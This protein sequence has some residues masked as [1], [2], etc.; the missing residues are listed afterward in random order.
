[1]KNINTTIKQTIK[2]VAVAVLLATPVASSAI[3][4]NTVH[5]AM[6][7]YGDM[8]VDPSQFGPTVHVSYPGLTD[9]SENA[10]SW[11]MYDVE[12]TDTSWRNFKGRTANIYVKDKSLLPAT[13]KAIKFWSP[14][15]KFKLVKS[16]KH[17]S[18]HSK[19]YANVVIYDENYETYAPTAGATTSTRVYENKN[20]KVIKLLGRRYQPYANGHFTAKDLPFLKEHPNSLI[21]DDFAPKA[22]KKDHNKAFTNHLNMVIATKNNSKQA[23]TNKIIANLG[24]TIGL[25]L[26]DND[27]TNATDIM[28]LLYVNDN[29]AAYNKVYHLTQADKDHID[30]IYSHPYTGEV[31]ADHAAEG[32]N[33]Y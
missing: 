25:G 16:A 33:I 8:H 13:K 23:V 15:F 30:W 18:F 4:S 17:A 20:K 11:D 27:D 28:G 9:D 26:I 24:Q 3:S 19:K 14:V 5:A 22:V 31:N 12:T 32:H 2:K 21:N 10:S 7:A 1:M 6:T 29:M